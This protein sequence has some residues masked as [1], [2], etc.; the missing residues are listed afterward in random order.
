MPSEAAA[1]LKE[2]AIFEVSPVL[3]VVLDVPEPPL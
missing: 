2:R 1:L 3:G